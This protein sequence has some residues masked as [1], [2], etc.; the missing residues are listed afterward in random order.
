MNPGHSDRIKEFF[1]VR[2]QD[3]TPAPVRHVAHV[4]Y[5]PVSSDP[6]ITR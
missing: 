3:I 4:L 5:A 6:E 2:S 1:A